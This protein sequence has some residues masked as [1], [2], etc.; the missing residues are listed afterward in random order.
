MA[1]KQEVVRQCQEY[2]HKFYPSLLE[3]LATN[4]G[5][6]GWNFGSARGIAPV[7]VVASQTGRLAP[8][9]EEATA[10]WAADKC[11]FSLHGLPN[12]LLALDL[13]HM[14]GT[15]KESQKTNIDSVWE[16]AGSRGV[17][18]LCLHLQAVQGQARG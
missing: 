4:L 15:S 7:L 1:S 3:L 17:G 11:R 8:K 16:N 5:K 13:D 14:P 10:V 12:F 18:P 6:E 2:V 9:E